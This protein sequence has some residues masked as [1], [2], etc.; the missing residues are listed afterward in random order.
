MNDGV[1]EREGVFIGFSVCVGAGVGVLAVV[2]CMEEDE[3]YVA[4]ARTIVKIMHT[5]IKGR[6]LFRSCG[7]AA[8]HATSP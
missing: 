1:G 5:N 4:P 3:K 2:V 6:N 7:S 8:C